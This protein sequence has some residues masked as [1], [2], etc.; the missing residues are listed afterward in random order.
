MEQE[1][2]RKLYERLG[3]DRFYQDYGDQYTNPHEAQVKQLVLQNQERLDYSSVLDFC[4]GGGEVSQIL[5]N[6]GYVDFKASD[7]Y[8]YRL[9]EQKLGKKCEKWSFDQVLRGQMSGEYSCIICSFA[10]HLCDENKLYNLCVQ[11]FQHTASL[12]ILTP[13][14]RPVLENFEGIDLVFEDHVLTP[15]GKKI[16]LK[17]YTCAWK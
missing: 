16:Y 15:K 6:L 5:L 13:H 17:T 11:L 1:H 9:Y 3:V 10:M 12:V 7:P 14:K 8:T 4:A 2:I